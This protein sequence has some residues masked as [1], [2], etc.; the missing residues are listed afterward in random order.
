MTSLQAGSGKGASRSMEPFEPKR[1]WT[2]LVV[3]ADPEDVDEVGHPDMGREFNLRAYRL[4]LQALI[5]ALRSAKCYPPTSVF[6][7][8]FGV[9]FYLRFWQGLD[10]KRVFGIDLSASASEHARRSFPEFDLRAGDIVEL[11]QCS[12]WPALTSSFE[13]VTAIDV[14]YH[15]TDAQAALQAVEN[16]AQLVAP[17]GIFLLTDKFPNTSEPFQESPQVV[18]RP[19]SWYTGLLKGRGLVIEQT[20]PVFWCMDP[21]LFYKSAVLPAAAAYMLWGFM[22]AGIKPWPRNSRL[23]NFLGSWLGRLGYLLDSA[24]V[25]RLT[26][27]PNLTMAIYRRQQ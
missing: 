3:G 8:A 22:R 12:D 25:P 15:I 1:Y 17:N 24:V 19:V 6:E 5:R 21:P 20:I 18:R 23:Q 14:L 9:G 27:T 10:S 4:R 2:N 16:L 7:A 26:T 13:V 11:N